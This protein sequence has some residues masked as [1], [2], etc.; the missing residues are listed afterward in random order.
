M[1]RALSIVLKSISHPKNWRQ[2]K[3]RCSRGR[4]HRNIHIHKTDPKR[5]VPPPVACRFQ[6]LTYYVYTLPPRVVH[7][8][9]SRGNYERALKP[10]E[11][12]VFVELSG[13]SQ[14]LPLVGFHVLVLSETPIS[15]LSLPSISYCSSPRALGRLPIIAQFKS[16]NHKRGF[17][18]SAI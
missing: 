7:V 6:V 17:T 3:I 18:A 16:A 9:V 1:V 11:V 4:G 2:D 8:R 13:I 15:M 14:H 10:P 5:T 12:P